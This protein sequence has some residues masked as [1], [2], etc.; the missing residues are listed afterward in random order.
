[1]SDKVVGED[2]ELRAVVTADGS[3]TMRHFV[4][5]ETYH[6]TSG[7]Q[8]EAQAL[9]INASGLTAKL[10]TEQPLAVLDIGLGLGY[11]ALTT[12]E[13]WLEASSPGDLTITSLEI[14]VALVALLVRG[15]GLWQCNWPARWRQLLCYLHADDTGYSGQIPHPRANGHASWRI[16]LGDA[17]AASLSPETYHYLWQDAFSPAN[18]PDLW[19][20]QF[21]AKLYAA[22]APGAILQTYSVARPV[23]EALQQAGWSVEKIPTATGIKKHWLRATR[24][25]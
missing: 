21:F 12:L 5:G 23:R 20:P 11:N 9:Y 8:A 16:A 6:S 22:A 18:N 10:G 3:L 4:H 15:E 25:A 1:M 14:D 24:L 7:A 19:T 17:G 2:T 13:V